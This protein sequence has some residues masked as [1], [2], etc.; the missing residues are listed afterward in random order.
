MC[1]NSSLLLAVCTLLQVLRVTKADNLSHWRK[2]DPLCLEI[3]VKSPTKGSLEKFQTAAS[4][5]D[6]FAANFTAVAK[7]GH[8]IVTCSNCFPCHCNSG[9]DDLL[10]LVSFDIMVPSSL[11][12]EITKL[13][14]ASS[15]LF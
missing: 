4:F 1:C 5:D 9:S 13:G 3:S 14:L 2:D 11:F 6:C 10:R 12:C 15:L 7:I 8:S